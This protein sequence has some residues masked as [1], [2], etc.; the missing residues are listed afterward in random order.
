LHYTWRVSTSA[1]T[2]L[3]GTGPA[4]IVSPVQY[5]V[6]PSGTTVIYGPVALNVGDSIEIWLKRA[7]VDPRWGPQSAG[8]RMRVGTAA[9]QPQSAGSPGRE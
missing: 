1:A 2:T 8:I 4:T 3:P 9:S 7:T 5:G 6:A